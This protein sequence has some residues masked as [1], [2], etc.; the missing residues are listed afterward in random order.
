MVAMMQIL[1]VTISLCGKICFDQAEQF[2][3]TIVIGK[4]CKAYSKK[5]FPQQ[6]LAPEAFGFMRRMAHE[7]LVSVSNVQPTEKALR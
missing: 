3:G 6:K 1:F 7:V 2:V 5:Y 4:A